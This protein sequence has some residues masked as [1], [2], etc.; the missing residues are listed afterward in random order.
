MS[1]NK[2][3][4]GQE[5]NGIKARKC[6]ERKSKSAPEVEKAAA[7]VFYCSLQPSTETRGE[8]GVYVCC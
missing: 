1:D 5:G 3:R 7:A 4:I 6:K 2:D 8:C